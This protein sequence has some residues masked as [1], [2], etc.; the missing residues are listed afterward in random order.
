MKNLLFIVVPAALVLT[1][2]IGYYAY[3]GTTDATATCYNIPSNDVTFASAAGY[4]SGLN[5]NKAIARAHVGGIG[6]EIV[7]GPSEGSVYAFKYQ[8]GTLG[9]PAK[10]YGYAE[11]FTDDGALQFKKRN[12]SC[13][14][15]D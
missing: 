2:V 4:A 8:F 12:A 10:A 7:A 3:A 5:N 6:D 1:L 11:G 15:H 9:Q 13:N 14:I